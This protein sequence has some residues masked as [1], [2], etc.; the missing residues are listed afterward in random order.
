MYKI[1][2]NASNPY[3]ILI[4][5]DFYKEEKKIPQ[6]INE[7]F[8]S[9]KFFIFTDNNIKSYADELKKDLLNQNRK[10][11]IISLSP[12]EEMKTLANVQKAGEILAN[13]GA[14]R[15][16]IIIALGG[17]VVGDFAGFMAASYMRGIKLVQIPISLLAMVDSC[18]GGKVAVDLPQGKNLIGFFHNPSL[19]VIDIKKLETLPKTEF[20]SGLGEI[21]KYAAISDGEF[22][23]KMGNYDRKSFNKNLG[24]IIMTCLE[25]KKDIVEKDELEHGKRKLLNFGH[26]IGHAVEN[27]AG[28][29]KISH[30][31]A[32][33]I[34]MNEM[35]KI[36]EKKGW[37]KKGTHSK[38]LNLCKK[39]DLPVSIED[40]DKNKLIEIIKMDKKSRGEGIDIVYIE[41][42]G[43]PIIKKAGWDFFCETV[44]K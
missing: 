34:G 38:I 37:T 1:N 10:S 12:G 9:G 8:P 24:Q 42:I 21:I 32:V 13:Y 33:A 20:D 29:G 2:V 15:T 31:A 18:V 43:K 41:D 7:K 6:I 25:I 36:T 27:Q 16:D 39:Y 28:Y 22:F 3:E 5:E 17:G 40:L 26:T 19:V 23:E 35:T 4:S 11:E 44:K 14:D 30:G